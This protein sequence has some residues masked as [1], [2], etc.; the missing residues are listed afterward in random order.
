MTPKDFVKKY[1]IGVSFEQMYALQDK[2][3]R[4]NNFTL[5]DDVIKYSDKK[6]YIDGLT[7]MLSAYILKETMPKNV[8]GDGA[9]ANFEGLEVMIPQKYDEYLTRLYGDYMTPPPP[10][11]RIGHHYYE[12][13]DLERSYI[14]TWNQNN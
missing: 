4:V 2:M 13:V 6:R 10:E 9:I 12:I 11:K 14:D 8:F 7:Y 1:G 3:N 5:K